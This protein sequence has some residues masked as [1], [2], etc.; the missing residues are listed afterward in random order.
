L[1]WETRVREGARYL[2]LAGQRPEDAGRNK[3]LKLVLS[4]S[5]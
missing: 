1:S 4:H 5:E 2:D 3:A